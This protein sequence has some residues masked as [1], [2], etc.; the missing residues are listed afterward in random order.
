MKVRD[1]AALNCSFIKTTVG[2]FVCE[3]TSEFIPREIMLLGKINLIVFIK[4]I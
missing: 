3:V 2:D 1:N 4:S